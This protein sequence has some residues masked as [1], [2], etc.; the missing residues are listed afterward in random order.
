MT[1]Q[2]RKPILTAFNLTAE[3]GGSLQLKHWRQVLADKTLVRLVAELN[4]R[5]TAANGC[6]LGP[7]S[8]H[9]PMDNN[10]DMVGES[11][12]APARGT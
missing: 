9:R 1:L 4:Y 6:W 7:R 5:T 10:F 11:P 12:H 3:E 2:L 8:K